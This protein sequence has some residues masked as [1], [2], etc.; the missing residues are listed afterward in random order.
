MNLLKF[1]KS[2]NTLNTYLFIST[3]TLLLIIIYFYII[4]PT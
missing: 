2:F 4:N 3:S 1:I